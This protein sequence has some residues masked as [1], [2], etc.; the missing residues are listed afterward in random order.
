MSLEEKQK[1]IENEICVCFYFPFR[2]IAFSA[3]LTSR[4][5]AGLGKDWYS[6]CVKSSQ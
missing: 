4:H 1:V 6:Q 2:F 3:A 5:P